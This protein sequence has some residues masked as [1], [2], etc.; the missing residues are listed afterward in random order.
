MFH[1]IG[2]LGLFAGTLEPTQAK[3][4]LRAAYPAIVCD[5]AGADVVFCDGRRVPFE[6]GRRNKTHQQQLDTAD[7]AEQLT[8]P[9]RLGRPQSPPAVDEEP[10]RIRSQ[11]FLSAVYGQGRK[12]VRTHLATVRWMPRYNGKKLKV[13]TIGGVHLKLRAVSRELQKLPPSMARLAAHVSGTF[14]HRHIRG[15]KRLSA[16]AFAI[17]IDVAVKKSDYWRW[18]KPDRHG[19]YA[20]RNRI[21]FEIVQIFERN[22][23]IWG[24]KWYRFDTM[25]FEYR[26]ELVLPECQRLWRTKPSPRDEKG[27]LGR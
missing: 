8:Q 11:A 16:H 14:V 22:G 18:R 24:G 15:T 7:V 26:P 6:D 9:Y 21:P 3:T 13:T 4:C 1:F 25:H 10:G 5:V 17:A 23:F 20:Y 12:A 2:L 19:H 27:S